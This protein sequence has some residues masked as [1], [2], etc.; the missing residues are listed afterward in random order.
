MKFKNSNYIEKIKL[1]S[2]I[3]VFVFLIACIF[4]PFGSGLSINYSSDNIRNY[5][6]LF[7]F[8]FGGEIVS[9][10]IHYKSYGIAIL[11][12][13]SYLLFIV[14]TVIIC[15]YFF[16]KQ[17]AKTKKYLG[18]AAIL[19]FLVSFIIMLLSTENLLL[20]LCKAMYKNPE[21]ST[22]KGLLPNTSLGFGSWCFVLFMILASLSFAIYLIFSYEIN[23]KTTLNKSIIIRRF[24][25]TFIIFLFVFSSALAPFMAIENANINLGITLSIIVGFVFIIS[26]IYQL[27]IYL[28]YKENIVKSKK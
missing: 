11:P 19:I 25:F 26:I 10:T 28:I 2:K 24:I 5:D 9:K 8:M 27:R 3:C 18:F 13:M 4:I 7:S 22:N 21:A 16:V 1:I 15:V 23:I 6:S 12:L 17:T 20:T 14:A